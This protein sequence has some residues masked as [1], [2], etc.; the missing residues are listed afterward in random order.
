MVFE[1]TISIFIQFDYLLHEKIGRKG[2]LVF[3]EKKE[4]LQALLG[5][6]HNFGRV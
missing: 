6:A 2:K 3:E 5:I 4:I 1:L